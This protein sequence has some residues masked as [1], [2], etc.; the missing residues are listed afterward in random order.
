VRAALLVALAACGGPPA[1]APAAAP[2]PAVTATTEPAA[3]PPEPA[4]DELAPPAE[5]GRESWRACLSAAASMI[6]QAPAEQL[7]AVRIYKLLCAEGDRRRCF[8]PDTAPAV[9]ER[10]RADGLVDA[11]ADLAQLYRT[12]RATCPEDDSCADVLFL[13]ACKGG[14]EPSCVP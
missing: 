12:G 5:C 4:G 11:C 6:E 3:P 7:R 2:P 10:C 8:E 1:P 13:M 14:D 9:R